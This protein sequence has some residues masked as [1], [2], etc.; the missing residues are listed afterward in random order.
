MW[1]D[2]SIRIYEHAKYHIGALEHCSAVR[3]RS[4]QLG[5]TF[6]ATELIGKHMIQ[7]ALHGWYING[8]G[9]EN[10]NEVKDQYFSEA[11]IG[12]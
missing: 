4:I 1:N 2:G 9:G 10:L 5:C 6:P 11:S 12:P 8:W 7:W 3:N